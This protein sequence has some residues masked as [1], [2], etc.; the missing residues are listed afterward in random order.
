MILALSCLIAACG[1]GR[2]K[3]ASIGEPEY[4]VV[5]RLRGIQGTVTVGVQI[6]TNGKVM[7]AHGSGADPILVKA[8]DANARDWIFGPFPAKF[9]F[10][11]Y[12]EITYVFRLRGHPTGNAPEGC[13][14][15]TNLPDRIEIS[16]TP[17]TGD[18]WQ[19]VPAGKP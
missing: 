4:P 3:V 11:F 2:L 10:P 17:V 6:G 14:V 16:A 1:G 15:T 7:W 5:A 9:K 13:D 8:A 19:R 12:H 18:T